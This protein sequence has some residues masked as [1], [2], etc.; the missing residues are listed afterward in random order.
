MPIQSP[1][2]DDLRYD[3]IVEQLLRRIP[4][5]APE[6]TDH[7]AH[8][9]GI[10]LME[11]LAWVA[12]AQLYSLSRQGVGFD[13]KPQTFDGYSFANAIRINTRVQQRKDA[14]ERMADQIDRKIGDDIRQRGNVEHV[15]C[16]A[17]QRARRPGAVAMPA[18][19]HGIDVEMFTERTRHPI[20]IARVIQAAM[21]Q[22]QRRLAFRSPIPELQLQPVGVKEMRNGFQ[23]SFMF[24]RRAAHS[25]D[26][27]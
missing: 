1:Q 24:T 7:N 14:A 23:D 15:F 8:D 26:A 3:A 13:G 20:P 12:E 25:T 5:Y 21:H 2:L 10:M 27:R 6:W 4:V 19:I 18:Q 22:N 17:I 9:P 16:D 11:L